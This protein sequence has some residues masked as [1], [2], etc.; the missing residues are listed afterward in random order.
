MTLIKMA[1]E[2][3]QNDDFFKDGINMIPLY[4]IAKVQR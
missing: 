1:H 3:S 4:I 2:F